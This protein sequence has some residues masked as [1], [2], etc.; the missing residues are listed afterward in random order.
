MMALS[1][2][3]PQSPNERVLVGNETH[4]DAGAFQLDE[5]TALVQTVDFFTPIVDDPRTFGAIAAVNALSDIYA[6]GARPLTALNLVAFP[7]GILPPSVLGEILQG[8]QDVLDSAGVALIGGHSVDDS[9]PK[10]GYAITGIADPHRIWRN[11]TASPGQDVYLTKPIGTGVI[12]KA[13]KD[14]TV[15]PEWADGAIQAML[16]SNRDAADLLH[17]IGGPSACTDVT[18]FGLLGH[19][20]EMAESAHVRFIV[21]AG[22]VPILPGAQELARQDAFPGGSRSNLT[23]FS[24]HIEN[25]SHL[26]ASHVAL[27]FD[28]VTSGGLLF[29]ADPHQRNP[30]EQRAKEMALEL[31][32]IGRVEEGSPTVVLLD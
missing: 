7:S 16:T 13:I 11:S 15:L 21:E 6:M 20:W 32:R 14:G 1:S 2:L 30:L 5:H 3:T 10:M 25:R 29:T 31:Y 23:Y 4:D 8:G 27:L 28:A 22:L 18:G 12:A 9:E 19:I 26:D 17:R 24:P